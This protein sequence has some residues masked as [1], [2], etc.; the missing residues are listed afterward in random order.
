MTQCVYMQ[1]ASNEILM[2]AVS[3]SPGTRLRSPVHPTEQPWAPLTHPTV[4]ETPG[5]FQETPA[6]LALRGPAHEA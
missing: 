5:G 3:V 1:R 6:L 2:Y 4:G